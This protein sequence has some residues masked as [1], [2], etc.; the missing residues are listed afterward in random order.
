MGGYIMPQ[1]KTFDWLRQQLNGSMRTQI[2]AAA[3]TL[4]LAD[5]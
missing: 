4:S 5:H 2:I 1:Q 3:A